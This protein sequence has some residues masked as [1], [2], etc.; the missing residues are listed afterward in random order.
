MLINGKAE[1]IPKSKAKQML[2]H[3]RPENFDAIPSPRILNSHLSFRFLPEQ[4]LQKECKIIHIVRNPKDVLV[5]LYNHNI[6][7]KCYGYDGKWE[8][9]LQLFLEDKCEYVKNSIKKIRH[10]MKSLIYMLA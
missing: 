6:G 4:L 8:D 9:F 1:T 2:E 3:E 5:S 10:S 7:V